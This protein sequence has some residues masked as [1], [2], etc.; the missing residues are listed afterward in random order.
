ML[1]SVLINI[2]GT[3]LLSAIQLG[4]P[5][6]G[7]VIVIQK[8]SP[9]QQGTVTGKSVYLEKLF[10]LP[11]GWPM[12]TYTPVDAFN[13]TE[14]VEQLYE[15]N[16]RISSLSWQDP[17]LPDAQVV[18][19]SDIVNQINLFFMLPSRQLMLT[20]LGVRILRISEVRNPY[21]EN[22]DHQFEAH[23]NFD[24]VT[25][26]SRTISMVTKG[27]GVVTGDIKVVLP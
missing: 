26:H 13:V 11:R 27:T 14:S 15:T 12:T 25:T 8:N 23:P 1:D 17:A 10:D 2:L 4:F 20:A 24:I 3:E 9:T 7:P 16:F 21:F 5:S 19:A 6:V 18:T 22:D